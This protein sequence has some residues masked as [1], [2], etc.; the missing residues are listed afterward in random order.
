MVDISKYDTSG[1][2]TRRM[3]EKVMRYIKTGVILDS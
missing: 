1:L 3:Y 2:L